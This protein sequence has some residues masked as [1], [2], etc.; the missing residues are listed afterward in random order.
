MATSAER[1]TSGLE[2]LL[3]KLASSDAP[4]DR[5]LAR[6]I[7]TR[8]ANEPTAEMPLAEPGLPR[9]EKMRRLSAIL[10]RSPQENDRR[11]G[12]ALADFDQLTRLCEAATNR[13]R[14]IAPEGAPPQP[15]DVSLEL[16]GRFDAT[17]ARWV[18]RP[19]RV[20]FRIAD[21]SH[22]FAIEGAEPAAKVPANPAEPSPKRRKPRR[23]PSRKPASLELVEM[24]DVAE[25]VDGDEIDH[26]LLVDEA[27]QISDVSRPGGD[28]GLVGE[29]S[30]IAEHETET[31][32]EPEAPT[33]SPD[34]EI[35][36][37]PGGEAKSASLEDAAVSSSGPSAEDVV[38]GELHSK[39]NAAAD[40]EAESVL[41]ETAIEEDVP[42]P[43]V[44]ETASED[45]VSESVG[46]E[47]AAIEED[48][49]ESIVEETASEENVPESV[50]LEEAAIED[51]ELQSVAEEE[52]TIAEIVEEEAFRGMIDAGTAELID[53]STDPGELL[54]ALE[55]TATTIMIDGQPAPETVAEAREDEEEDLDDLIARIAGDH[56]DE[57]VGDPDPAME[58]VSETEDGLDL[59]DLRPAEPPT[60]EQPESN[61]LDRIPRRIAFM[62]LALPVRME[63][64]TLVCMVA[65]ADDQTTLDNLATISGSPIRAVET[66]REELLER[67]KAAYGEDDGD[68]ERDALLDQLDDV[69]APKK[70]GFLSKLLRRG[71]KAA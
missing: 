66:D 17:L 32:A 43:V 29:V 12:Q 21:E 54:A 38:T 45:E 71:G 24:S 1:K 30:P 41:E 2:T 47:E 68:A 46:L 35:A 39:E 52:T 57:P 37:E 20:T 63:G 28:P 42:E 56:E 40:V 11:L 51:G 67:L 9:A 65:S 14:N 55:E 31:L 34:P 26:G 33:E 62:A 60:S 61:V 15:E 69:P 64:E 7:A 59:D 58:D 8:P 49:P 5:L 4:G 44:E 18:V 13:L 25:A 53:T 16:E 70:G 22:D 3:H 23:S 10:A 19:V 50:G 6:L 27:K 36:F 48:V